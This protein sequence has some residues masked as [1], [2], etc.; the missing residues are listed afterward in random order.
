MQLFGHNDSTK[1]KIKIGNDLY[2]VDK[3]NYTAILL[4][5][6]VLKEKSPNHNNTLKVVGKVES[7][8]GSHSVE[9]S[10]HSSPSNTKT[11]IKD[12]KNFSIRMR[13]LRM[14]SSIESFQ[15]SRSK[16]IVLKHD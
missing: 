14:D 5:P 8:K 4:P 13:P 12:E 11:K 16:K 3:E 1:K 7:P 9:W 10:L 15:A 2:E 6:E